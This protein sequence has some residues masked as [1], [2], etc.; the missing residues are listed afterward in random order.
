MFPLFHASVA[1]VLCFVRSDDS[2]E[3]KEMKSMITMIQGKYEDIHMQLQEKDRYHLALKKEM[4]EMKTDMQLRLRDKDKQIIEISKLMTEK[5][6]DLTMQLREKDKMITVLDGRL[7]SLE[8][9]RLEKATIN[10][11]VQLNMRM[12]QAQESKFL[13]HSYDKWDNDVSKRKAA[14]KSQSKRQSLAIK[15]NPTTQYDIRGQIQS[16]VI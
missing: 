3:L 10:K 12:K 4:Y 13:K 15:G 9:F 16:Q 5:F 8:L 2:Q 11:S 14:I 6:R 7:K 1:V